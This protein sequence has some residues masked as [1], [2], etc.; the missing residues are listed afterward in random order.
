MLL[1]KC[2]HIGPVPCPESAVLAQCFGILAQLQVIS[3]LL[4]AQYF[5]ILAQLQVISQLLLAQCFG[6]LAQLQVTSQMY[7]PN[8]LAYWPSYKS[9]VRCIGP[10]LW[11]NTAD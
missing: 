8:A 10:T 2:F 9:S 11:A 7:C 3:Q 6:I 5:G 4:L 1:I